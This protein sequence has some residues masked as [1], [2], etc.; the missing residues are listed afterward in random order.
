MK[1]RGRPLKQ[2][3]FA[4]ERHSDARTQPQDA[5][6]KFDADADINISATP[7][8]A[9]AEWPTSP[10]PD[11]SR[12][13]DMLFPASAAAGVTL[14]S[15]TATPS[16]I[17]LD[18]LD[19]P[20]AALSERLPAEEQQLAVVDSRAKSGIIAAPAA[21]TESAAQ[22]A[23]AYL[24][25]IHAF[26]PLFDPDQ[27]TIAQSLSRPESSALVT[28]IHA[29]AYGVTLSV[30]HV[31]ASSSAAIDLVNSQAALINA[32][33]LFGHGGKKQALALANET[34][35]VIIAH[36]WHKV[37]VSD[38]PTLTEDGSREPVRRLYWETR[39]LEGVLCHVLS[40]PYSLILTRCESFVRYPLE[41]NLV[42]QLLLPCSDLGLAH[43]S[44]QTVAPGM[45]FRALDL[46]QQAS[47]PWL[48]NEA[49]A[50][51]SMRQEG[52]DNLR[53]SIESLHIIAK[54]GLQSATTSACRG[55]TASV[56]ERS[57][58]R[59]AITAAK[60]ATAMTAVSSIYLYTTYALATQ[61]DN[62]SAMLAHAVST[63]PSACGPE[64][65]ISSN[66]LS[67]H[68][69]EQVYKWS[70][71]IFNNMRHEQVESKLVDPA[72]GAE[73]VSLDGP[74]ASCQFLIAA[75]A[76]TYSTLLREQY[77][78][79]YS[80]QNGSSASGVSGR[81]QQVLATNLELAQ[82]VC[83]KQARERWA[84][85]QETVDGIVKLR[86]ASALNGLA[87]AIEGASDVI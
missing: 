2:N 55:L 81:R 5:P 60:T 43:I 24:T 84:V 73:D 64:P 58:S 41:P 69:T 75:V 79:S 80:L 54:D 21:T 67:P 22:A 9:T 68:A 12:M 59:A 11:V 66:T 15:S 17:A 35:N 46:L 44:L 10:S 3:R 65:S 34:A 28:A 27:A 85:A 82:H 19:L 76:L 52:L 4:T 83:E 36:S 37:D 42:S 30:A 20:R 18:A 62:V 72:V 6:Y 77:E 61:S 74:C 45:R 51:E 39:F 13:F 40:A 87:V 63:V 78:V 47:N 71:A 25:R 32:Y 50:S 23:T 14:N 16:P 48:F 31:K 57:S 1:K 70:L 7:A 26:L 38:A 53:S 33:A 29:L 86:H 8:N 49:D 56:S